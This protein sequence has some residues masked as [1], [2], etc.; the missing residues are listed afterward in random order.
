[1]VIKDFEKMFERVKN[2]FVSKGFAVEV[3]SDVQIR[4]T[5]G[6]KTVYLTNVKRAIQIFTDFSHDWTLDVFPRLS[7]VTV[8]GNSIFYYGRIVEIE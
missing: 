4:M 8:C 1:M 5:K 7:A 6:N 3:L 2:E